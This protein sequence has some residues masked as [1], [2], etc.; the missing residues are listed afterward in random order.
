MGQHA[1][2]LA[3]SCRIPHAGHMPDPRPVAHG[4]P[5]HCN[6]QGKKMQFL[7]Y[8][9]T[10]FRREW[11]LSRRAIRRPILFRHFLL[12][13]RWKSPNPIRKSESQKP[14]FPLKIWKHEPPF[15]TRSKRAVTS[16]VDHWAKQHRIVCSSL[17]WSNIKSLIK[18]K[19]KK[20]FGLRDH[21][22]DET[23]IVSKM[24]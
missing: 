3:A 20:N 16:W 4:S 10:V 9:S 13:K 21:K 22:R 6:P 14:F 17:K 5:D 8:L 23:P 18:G 1:Y 2:A 12:K 15:I 7:N 11:K 19:A 24:L